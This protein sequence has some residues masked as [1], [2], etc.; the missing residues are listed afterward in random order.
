MSLL[1]ENTSIQHWAG[2][3]NPKLCICF[4]QS[5]L[6]RKKTGFFAKRCFVCATRSF[7][8]AVPEMEQMIRYHM[9]NGCSRNVGTGPE[10][11]DYTRDLRKQQQMPSCS[12]KEYK[13][14]PSTKC[15]RIIGKT[16]AAQEARHKNH[17]QTHGAP[18]HSP[19]GTS[20]PGCSA[21]RAEMNRHSEGE[22]EG[23][24]EEP[25]AAGR[26]NHRN[27]GKVASPEGGPDNATRDTIDQLLIRY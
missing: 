25:A 20:T 12:R 5:V 6:S 11:G 13:V 9:I 26:S 3:F 2:K 24:V 1:L 19:S 17:T 14:I 27:Y 21:A 23:R 8:I 22:G 4:V 16:F 18:P 10:I 7:I 15:H